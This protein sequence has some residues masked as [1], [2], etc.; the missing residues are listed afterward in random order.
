MLVKDIKFIVTENQDHGSLYTFLVSNNINE[1]ITILDYQAG[2]GYRDIET[3][4]RDK[5]DNFWLAK[6]DIRK[7]PEFN[8]D[9]AIALIKDKSSKLDGLV[10][11]KQ[12]ENSYE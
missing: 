5:Q 2:Y 11:S 10:N 9:E 3:G 1:R 8:V 12:K 7:Y 6:F 4:Y